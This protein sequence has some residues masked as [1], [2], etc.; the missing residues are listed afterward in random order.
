MIQDILKALFKSILTNPLAEK[1]SL[2]LF[3]E[4]FRKFQSEFYS[5]LTASALDPCVVGF[6]SVAC[7]RTGLDILIFSPIPQVVEGLGNIFKAYQSSGQDEI[8]IADKGF[9]DFVVRSTLAIAGT[10]KRPGG[11]GGELLPVMLKFSL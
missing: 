7:Y 11:F 5:S 8:R 4:L 6:K 10:Y 9:N 2:E 1:D 3:S